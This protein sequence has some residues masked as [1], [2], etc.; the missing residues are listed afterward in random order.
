M[1]FKRNIDRLPIPPADAKRHNVVCHY[2]I[3]G[4]GYHAYSW[5][6]NRQGGTAPSEN[7]FGVD[8]SQQQPLE[9]EAWYAPAM[10]NMVKQD[11]RDVHLVIKPDYD[12]VVNS[13]LAS[14]RG[15]R[16][17][18]M[19]YSEKRSTQ[20]QR[21]TDPLVWRYGQLQPT[22][23]DDA[24]DLVA[25]VTA[26]VIEEQGEDGLI[27][28]A[29]DHGGAGGGYEF[30]WGTGKLYFDPLKVRNIRIHNRPAYNSEVHATRDMG[31][32][33][34]NN[35][36]EDAELADTIFVVGAN[37]LEAQTNYFLN[38][39]VPNLQGTSL[40]KKREELPDEP[41]E[42]ARIVFV[43]PRRTVSV[44]ACEVEAGADNVLHLAVNP[45]TDMV[46]LNALLTHVADQ[47][48]IGPR[49]HRR[50][51]G[52]ERAGRRRGHARPAA[53]AAGQG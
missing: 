34:L 6:A 50:P 19:S 35:A 48:W 5:P 23:W 25:Q 14:P 24:L 36:Y 53:Q 16:M 32:G 39:W 42:R 51:H 11:G 43:D 12:C 13:G 49:L 52:P 18:E 38:H 27:V 47:G 29:S 46:L 10:Y 44:N 40:G 30:T 9:S 20:Q 2:C 28:S 8:L 22:G 3:V 17:A 1:A 45:G 37:P 26:R 15:G 7:A 41:H 4:C 21:L 31:I 33:E